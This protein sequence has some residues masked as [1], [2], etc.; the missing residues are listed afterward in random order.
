MSDEIRHLLTE[1]K[2]R[3][4]GLY[5]SRLKSLYLFGSYARGDADAES[6]VDVLIVLDQVDNYSQEIDFT[7]TAISE[8]SL[9]FGV[10]ISRVFASEDRWKNDQTNFF[11]NVRDEAVAA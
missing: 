6:D 3:L 11:L 10:T 9:R 1:L 4:D 8:L 5:G 7:G 2:A